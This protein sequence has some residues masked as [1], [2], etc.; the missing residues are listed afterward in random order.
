MPNDTKVPLRYSC[1]CC[2]RAPVVGSFGG[3]GSTDTMA[4]PTVPDAEVL[5]VS[6]LSS[7][8]P[9]TA[10]TVYK[11]K[12]Q[13]SRRVSFSAATR[14]GVHKVSRLLVSACCVV[15][16]VDLTGPSLGVG[17]VRVCPHPHVCKSATRWLRWRVCC[18]TAY[19]VCF[20]LE[21]YKSNL[22]MVYGTKPRIRPPFFI[23]ASPL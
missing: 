7:A 16:C 18:L 5:K 12:A 11:G 2:W 4:S 8:V 13:I 15:V 1:S 14:I 6:F 19:Q 23:T 10:V 22:C 3:I 17:C 20:S 9:V 21:Q